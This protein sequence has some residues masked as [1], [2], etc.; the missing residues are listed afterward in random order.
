MAVPKTIDDF[1]ALARKSGLVDMERLIAHLQQMQAAGPLPSDLKQLAD[2]LIHDGFLTYFQAE[3]FLM[4]KW[5]GFTLGKYDVLERLGVGGT[6]IVYLCQHKFMRRRVAVKVLATNMAENREVLERFYREAQAVAALDHPNIVRAHDIDHD[7]GFHFLVMEYVDGSSLDRLVRKQ[8]PMDIS[9]AAYCIRQAAQGLQHA[10]EAGLVHRDIKP[11]NLLLDRQGL[12]KILDMG[13]ARFFADKT[14]TSCAKYSQLLGTVDYLAPEQAVNSDQAD[15]RADIYS[16]GATFRYL[17]T[18]KPPFD[19]GSLAQKLIW[20]Q[21]RQPPTLRDQRPEVPVD[22]EAVIARTMAKD[23]G[24][25]YQTP[26]ALIDALGPWT[27]I[28]LPPIPVPEASRL[29][30]LARRS[31]SPLVTSGVP[32]PP[33]PSSQSGILR[34]G[35]PPSTAQHLSPAETPTDLNRLTQQ[36]RRDAL[37]LTNSPLPNSIPS[38]PAPAVNRLAAS[39]PESEPPSVPENERAAMEGKRV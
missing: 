13:L 4:G 16:L 31:G 39:V 33:I 14:D 2:T 28:P 34:K 38:P 10:H 37:T 5:R 7:G 27:K 6:G 15:I 32:M 36:M 29:S 30:P 35:P 1:L 19:E 18:G 11:A 8:G 22:L 3:Q 9:R 24:Q 25:R 23:P 21:M 20:H 17:L 12:V 26:A